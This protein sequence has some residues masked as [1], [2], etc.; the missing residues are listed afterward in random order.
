MNKLRGFEVVTKE[1]RKHPDLE[2]TLP[3]RGSANAAGYDLFSPIDVTLGPEQSILVWT[4]VKAYMLGDE[5]LEIYPRSGLATK[6]GMVLKNGVG[7]VDSDYYS[8]QGNDGNIG[9]FFI[10][11]GKNTAYIKAGDRV[12]QA[13]FKKFLVA[14]A[15]ESSTERVGGFGSTG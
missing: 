1:H 11:N 4:D 5:V 7:I 6:F 9:L 2:I 3:V 13:I 15:D 10:N 14:D 12:A 8:N